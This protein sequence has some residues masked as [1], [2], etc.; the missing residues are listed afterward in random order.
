LFLLEGTTGGLL[1]TGNCIVELSNITDGGIDVAA[2]DDVET[3]PISDGDMGDVN[4]ILG[5]DNTVDGDTLALVSTVVVCDSTLDVHTKITTLVDMYSSVALIPN[6]VFGRDDVDVKL[7][8]FLL[9][10]LLVKSIVLNLWVGGVSL[11]LLIFS[12]A[13]LVV[14][15]SPLYLIILSK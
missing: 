7:S 2:M 11:I 13:S 9:I 6:I 10:V 14:P 1:L 12:V 15:N 4:K 8:I 5:N 3:T